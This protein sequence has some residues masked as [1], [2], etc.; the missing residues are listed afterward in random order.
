MTSNFLPYFFWDMLTC[1][2]LFTSKQLL[3]NT[4]ISNATE[5]SS[6][7]SL[8][9][10]WEKENRRR[11]ISHKARPCSYL[12]VRIAQHLQFFDHQWLQ[13]TRLGILSCIQRRGRFEEESSGRLQSP[14]SAKVIDPRLGLMRIG[15]T[16]FNTLIQ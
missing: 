9:S 11:L 13:E 6:F 12:F 16:E 1:T 7:V 5:Q 10:H 3:S 2:R 8:A 4:I 14:Q 15:S